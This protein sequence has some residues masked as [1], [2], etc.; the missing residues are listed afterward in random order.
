MPTDKGNLLV[1]DDQDGPAILQQIAERRAAYMRSEYDFMP[2]SESPEQHRRRYKWLHREGVL[3]DE[4]LAQR[5]AAVE[6]AEAAMP[7]SDDGQQRPL[8]N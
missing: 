4:E 5:L 3:S 8:L 1:I 7:G 2:E 6:A